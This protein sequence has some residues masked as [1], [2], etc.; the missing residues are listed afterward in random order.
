MSRNG[1]IGFI[2]KSGLFFG[3]DSLLPDATA[4]AECAGL[5]SMSAVSEGVDE[6]AIR[7]GV[8]RNTF[9]GT[10]RAVSYTHLTLPT[11]REV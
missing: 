3:P 11:N 8:Y 7:P 10:I 5:G 4:A 6:K 9:R 1:D 2:G